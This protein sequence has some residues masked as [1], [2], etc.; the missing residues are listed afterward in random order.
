MKQHSR[1]LQPIINPNLLVLT[2]VTAETVG[3]GLPT[4]R[5]YGELLWCAGDLEFGAWDDDVVAVHG[6]GVVTA[7][8][9]VAERLR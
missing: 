9:T 8:V 3:D 1:E 5:C 2:A 6:A 7:V 4:C